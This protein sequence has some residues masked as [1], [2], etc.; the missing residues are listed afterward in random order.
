MVFITGALCLIQLL[1]G[2]L[3]YITGDYALSLFYLLPILVGTWIAGRV[4]GVVTALVASGCWFAA[5]LVLHE[6]LNLELTVW[7]SVSRLAVFLLLAVF[8]DRLRRNERI[9][10]EANQKLQRRLIEERSVARTDFLTDLPNSRALLEHLSSL[11][12][13]LPL[14]VAYLD[15]DEFKSV[16]DT[17]GHPAGDDLLRRVAEVIRSS[18]RRDDFAARIGGDEFVIAFAGADRGSAE[19]ICRR[20]LERV[21]SLAAEHPR[22]RLG[23]TAGIAFA[24]PADRDPESIIRRADAA[25]YRRK[26]REKG[27]MG[28]ED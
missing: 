23:L 16:N 14:A 10:A 18:I 20:I 11:P 7:N 19:T 13:E 9:L 6:G 26:S 25:M 17:Y 22:S 24:T 28:F 15:L 3:D 1:I 8:V 5:E 4:V 12:S 27:S 2:W 21:R